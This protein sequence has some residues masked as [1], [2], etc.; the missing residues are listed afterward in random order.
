MH[1]IE[2]GVP[3]TLDS[4]SKVVAVNPRKRKPRV[5]WSAA[6]DEI[7]LHT[8]S[9]TVRNHEGE[10]DWDAIS[11]RLPGKS[12]VQCLKRHMVITQKIEPV[13]S[14]SVS[15][16]PSLESD[17]RESLRDGPQQTFRSIPESRFEEGSEEDA[18]PVPNKKARISGEKEADGSYKW[19]QQEVDLLMKLVETYKDSAPRWNEVAANFSHHN[20]VDCLSKWQLISKP[21]VAKGKGKGIFIIKVMLVLGQKAASHVVASCLL[22]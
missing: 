9:N 2:E 17:P 20:E 1:A 15:S 19:T 6:E 8:I 13:L 4:F 10:E 14:R 21:P 18:P 16:S 7:L 3:V 11:Q 5:T 12:A 22:L